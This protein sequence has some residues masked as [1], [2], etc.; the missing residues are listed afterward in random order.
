MQHPQLQSLLETIG[1][2]HHESTVYMALLTLGEQSA[3]HIAKTI[4]MPRSTIRSILDKL[5]ERGV[6]G[7]VYR[8]STQ[9]YFC[10]DPEALIHSLE[11]DREKKLLDISRVR[12]AIPQFI[13]ARG[14]SS[15]NPK[16]QYFTGEK[17]VLE[18][19]NH[20]LYQ[21]IEEVLFITSYE[22][23]ASDL[24][25]KNDVDFY[26]P[27]RIKRGIKLRVLSEENRHAQ[28]FAS[29]SKKALRKH[30][31]LSSKKNLIGNFMIYGNFVLY[32]SAN[33]GEFMATLTESAAMTK[34]MKALFEEMWR[35]ASPY[36]I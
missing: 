7:K 35:K 16:V 24:V 32:F 28:H 25:Y 2:N 21:D 17:G 31:F 6:V 12:N 27:E 26:M 34:T 11:Q 4:K 18:A 33:S 15:S 13:D 29:H 19:C 3:S 30:R 9:Y 20:S 22:F 36:K 23:V 1:F 14:S 8:G 5:C 10:L